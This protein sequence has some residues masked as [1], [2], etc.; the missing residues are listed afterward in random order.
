VL[1]LAVPGS[2][3]EGPT[4]QS[5][6]AVADDGTRLA[7]EAFGTGDTIMVVHGGPGLGFRYLQP[8][9]APL[10]QRHTLVFFD[11]RGA[12]RSD[13]PDST[14][15]ALYDYVNDIEAVRR[16]LGAARVVVL[17]HSWGG[18]L[19]ALYAAAYP[20]HTR[21]LVLLAP[22]P[23]R[24]LWA[25][26]ASAAARRAA[27]PE[28]SHELG[29]LAQEMQRGP[30]PVAAC[31]AHMAILLTTMSTVAPDSAAVRCD[32]SAEV[33]RARERVVRWTTHPLGAW[34]WRGT[35]AWID[36][37]TLV[38]HG[39]DDTLPLAAAREWAGTIAE[40]RLV[41]IPGARHMPQLDVP[42]RFASALARFLDG[43]EHHRGRRR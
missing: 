29:R 14:R 30:D 9:L 16:H 36:V 27:P 28:T 7:W 22:M 20:Q 10:A 13:L 39:S 6:F 5:G 25:D 34:D 33:L 3:Q 18:A 11:Q 35:V 2:A 17:G 21:A 40:A 19:A 43:L 12:G 32:A 8:G 4:V 24:A 15:F 31:R 1:L 38:V 26:S 37:P 23:P 42:A 41:V